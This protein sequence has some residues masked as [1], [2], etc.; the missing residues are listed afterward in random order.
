MSVPGEPLDL[1][2]IGCGLRGTGLLT[3]VPELLAR[4]TA[5][6]EA[7]DSLGPG[8]FS[9]YRIES[10]SSGSDFFGW[11]DPRGPFGDVL[12]HPDVSGLRATP[13]NFRLPLLAR[14]LRHVGAA[15]AARVTPGQLFLRDRV[16]RVDSDGAVFTAT[17]A[18]GRSLAAR[19][20]VLA[21][22]IRETVRDDLAPWRSKVILSS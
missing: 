1:A 4:R 5:I 19:S 14:A 6:V 21:T 17:L 9:E 10:N 16:L 3:A 7:A 2:L 11:V 13:G 22:G 18:S 20:M 12:A 15:I 8:S